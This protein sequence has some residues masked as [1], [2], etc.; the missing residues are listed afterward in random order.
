MEMTALFESFDK[1]KA[2]GMVNSANA[3]LAATVI[4]GYLC[5]SASDPEYNTAE[6]P[7]KGLVGTSGFEFTRERA[8][9][10]SGSL[11]AG[12]RAHY[13][14]VHG[15]VENVADRAKY[16]AYCLLSNPITPTP[17]SQWFQVKRKV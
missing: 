7:L 17:S 4:P 13:V 14:A 5:P 16:T 2:G 11:Y 6:Y 12:G 15:A 8:S 9:F 3:N 10:K 1:T